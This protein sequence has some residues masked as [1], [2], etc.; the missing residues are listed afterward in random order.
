MWRFTL[1]SL[2]ACNAVFGLGDV[3]TQDATVRPDAVGC[4][5]VRFQAPTVLDVPMTDFTTG[6]GELYDP[7]DLWF[8]K[9]DA[10]Q[11]HIF[12]ASRAMLTDGFG[13]PMPATISAPNATYDDDDPAVT[14]DGLDVFFVS[15]RSGTAAVYE[16]TRRNTTDP[17]EA[18]LTIPQ[19]GGLLTFAGI[20]VAWDG[21]TLYVVDATGPEGSLHELHRDSR[22]DPFG[23]PSDAIASD[24]AWPSVSPDGTELFFV[25]RTSGRGVNRL[26]R[27]DP[28]FGTPFTVPATQDVIDANG[29]DP[30]LAPDAAHLVVWTGSEFEVF[31]RACP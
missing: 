24:V 22:E 16:A 5:G 31:E 9:Q 18:P 14:A 12:T 23:A 30:D 10:G 1:L 26:I 2:T 25:Q 27:A 17:F 21:L 11:R 13:S 6:D 8:A 28:T 7:L 4:S 19:T 3:T 20:D 15:N 29:L